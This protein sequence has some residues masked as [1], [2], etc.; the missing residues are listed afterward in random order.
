MRRTRWRVGKWVSGGVVLGLSLAMLAPF[1]YMVAASLWGEPGVMALRWSHY[2]AALTALPFGRFFLNS[3]LFAGCVV[4]GQ[5]LTSAAAAY[6]FARLRFP[7][8]DRVFLAFLSVLMIPAVVLLIPRFLIINA[9]GWVDSY[10]G[11]IIAEIV[12]VW[13]IFLLR[14]F[15]Q[16]IPRDLEDAARLDGAGEWTIFWRVMLPQTKPGLAT[17]A[18][19]AFVGQWKSFLWPLIAAPSAGMNV[20]EVGLARFHELYAV[21]WPYQMAAA[22]TVMVPLA[23]LFFVAQKYLIEAVRRS[24]QL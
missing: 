18:L 19:L 15:F 2:P 20:T 12:S 1:L 9:L 13:G 21:D 14:Q 24:A 7:G 23:I 10:Q 16:T 11:L 6:A 3:A 5:V 8:R 4:V 22:V 17:L